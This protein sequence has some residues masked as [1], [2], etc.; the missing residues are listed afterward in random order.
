MK[1][2]SIK[3]S[4]KV[5]L[6]ASEKAEKSAGKMYERFAVKARKGGF[7]EIAKAFEATAKS[8]FAHEKLMKS[9]AAKLTKK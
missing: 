6:K 5:F 1:N 4:L 2:A 7:D 3:R 9:L 8:E